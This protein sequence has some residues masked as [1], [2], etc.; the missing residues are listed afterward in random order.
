M[1][2]QSTA[3]IAFYPLNGLTLSPPGW[4]VTSAVNRLTSYTCVALN[5]TPSVSNRLQRF[6]QSTVWPLAVGRYT[7]HT[8]TGLSPTLQFT[9]AFIAVERL[10]ISASAPCMQQSTQYGGRIC[11]RNDSIW[12]RLTE[13]RNYFLV[14]MSLA[15]HSLR[16]MTFRAAYELRRSQ[17]NETRRIST[18]EVHLFVVRHR[19]A[20]FVIVCVVVKVI[21]TQ[22]SLQQVIAA[23]WP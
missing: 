21:F 17:C 20:F 3:A 16:S 13:P 5:S 19:D 23:P 7:C 4:R 18:Q 1:T 14:P 11:G 15:D 9:V 2:P 6:S 12:K 8:S 10:V 22:F